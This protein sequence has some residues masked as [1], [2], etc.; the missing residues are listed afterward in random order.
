MNFDR[1]RTFRALAESL[2]F[3]KTAEVLHISQSAVS[4]QISA[5]AQCVGRFARPP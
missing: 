1:R 3:R 4:Q 5:G 2:H